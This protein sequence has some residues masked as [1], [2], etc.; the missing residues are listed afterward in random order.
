MSVDVTDKI[1]IVTGGGRGIG[2][3]IA[4]VL[5][6]NGADVVVADIILDNARSVAAEILDL[7]RESMAQHMDVTV[8]ESVDGMVEAVLGRF[9]RIDILVNNAGI[10]GA[11]GW[12]EREAPNEAD[13]AAIH[14]VNVRGVARVTEA[15]A[16]HMKER[17]YGK[18][19]NIASVAG[20]VGSTTSSAYGASKASV[21]NMT[22]TWSVE[23]AEFNIN[24]NAICPGI[25][26]TPMWLRVGTHFGTIPGEEQGLTPREVFS[27]HVQRR[28]PLKREQTPEDI[29]NAIAFLASDHAKNI[30]GQT[31]NVSG[32]THMN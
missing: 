13:W 5:A 3:G 20:R 29:G 10:V 14:A 25:L 24:V 9:G 16:A 1:A 28:I 2:R 8:Q 19:V 18:I 21:I 23:L 27:V 12:E 6:H 15:V 4:T 7:G 26:W 30:T 22:Q 32:G 17:R 31:L 11:A